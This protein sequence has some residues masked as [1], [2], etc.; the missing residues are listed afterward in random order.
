VLEAR[1]IWCAGCTM[2]CAWTCERMAFKG[3]NHNYVQL[4]NPHL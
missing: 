3:E 2:K 1:S 4:A